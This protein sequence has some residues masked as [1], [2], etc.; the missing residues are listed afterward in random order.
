MGELVCIVCPNGC[1]L[2]CEER[3]GQLF[4]TGNKCARGAA[5]AAEELHHPMRT[6]CS[7]VRTVFAGMPV[8]PPVLAG[9]VQLTVA[10]ALLGTPFTPVGASGTVKGVTLALGADAAL[11]PAALVAFTVKV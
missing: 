10:C 7:T 6:V 11:S 8:L 2:R 3:D 1:T 4:V 5:F 9:A